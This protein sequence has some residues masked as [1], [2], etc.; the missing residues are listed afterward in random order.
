MIRRLPLLVSLLLFILFPSGSFSATGLQREPRA[1][2]FVS[3]LGGIYRIAG[4]RASSSSL[5][6]LPSFFERFRRGAKKCEQESRPQTDVDLY[7]LLGLHRDAPAHAVAARVEEL[8]KQQQ[9][10][11]SGADTPPLDTL[12]TTLLHEVSETLQNPKQ[13][14][15]Y[16]EGG[17]IPEPLHAL[18]KQ[19]LPARLSSSSD[20]ERT[21]K[22]TPT[23]V[24]QEEDLDVADTTRGPSNLFSALFGPHFLGA[25]SPFAAVTGRRHTPQ[26]QRGADVEST[27]TL[28]FVDAALRGASSLPVKVQ[29]Q[30]PCDVCSSVEDRKPLK[31]SACRL[32]EGR[33]MQTEVRRCICRISLMHV[34]CRSVRRMMHV[35]IDA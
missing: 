12:V 10:Q 8:Q 4:G 18:L 6:S 27:I 13:R 26:P 14:A 35:F 20:E 15:A 28:G 24:D 22:K 19:L 25:N 33:G 1:C 32:C 31:A 11:F 17:Y 29:R 34:G 9:E 2:A 30:E 16:D 21:I 3:H 23:T 7:R 5:D